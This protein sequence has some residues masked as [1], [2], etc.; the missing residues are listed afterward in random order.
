MIEVA[1]LGTAYQLLKVAIMSVVENWVDDYELKANLPCPSNETGAL[2][3]MRKELNL[4]AAMVE[5]FNSELITLR[6][7]ASQFQSYNNRKLYSYLSGYNP[8]ITNRDA[9]YAEGALRSEYWKRVMALTDVLSVMNAEKRNEWDKQFDADRYL[10]SEQNIPE[11]SLDGVVSTVMGLLNDRNQFM[12]ERVFG[13]FKSLSKS[14]KTNKAFGFSTRMIIT[15]ICEMTKY[16]D[17]LRPEFKNSNVEPLSE[18]RVVCAF[19][20]GDAVTAVHDTMKLVESAV[21]HSGFRNWESID[22]NSI[23]YRLYKNGSMHIEVHPDI[24]ERLNNILAAYIPLALPSERHTHNKQTVKTF[25]ELK[26]CIDFTS[27]MQLRDILF[28]QEKGKEV[29][30]WSFWRSSGKFGSNDHTNQ[31]IS[32]VLRFIGA[33]MTTY[34]VEMDYDPKEVLR[35]IIQNGELPDIVSYQYYPSTERISDYIVSLLGAGEGDT[36]LE[37]NIGQADLIQCLPDSVAVTGIELD[38]LNCLVSRSKGYN[39]IHDDFLA[40]SSKNQQQKFTC[41]AM[42][43]PFADNRAKLHLLAAA[44]HVDQGG[45]LTAVLPL[46]LQH[47]DQLL[48]DQFHTE[49]GETFENEFE[50]TSI[51]VRVLYAERI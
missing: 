21:N 13:V 49:W 29:K 39:V 37:P 9:V 45:R 18:L 10:A 34:Q 26:K 44:S 17:G 41:V 31:V 24:A 1:N 35:Y 48:G 28:K 33:R 5:E 20:R 51:S 42:N 2:P 6:E 4:I 3:E 46:S 50:N 47:H 23:R 43:P 32:D 11:F 8:Q 7:M 14:H 15:G 16:S 30:V 25:P 27:R 36:L 40:W 22:G 12:K 19:F 38:A